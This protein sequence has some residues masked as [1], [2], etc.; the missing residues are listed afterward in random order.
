MQTDNVINFPGYTKLDIDPDGVLEGAKGKLDTVLVL[1]TCHN[2]DDWL[3]AST[4]NP[5]DLLMLVEQFKFRLLNGE[6]YGD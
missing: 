6:F 5:A 4:S 3:A 2:G 1:G